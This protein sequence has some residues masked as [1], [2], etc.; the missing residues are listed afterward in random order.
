[1]NKGTPI[2]IEPKGFHNQKLNIGDH[3]VFCARHGMREGYISDISFETHTSQRKSYPIS[4]SDPAFV[5][6]DYCNSPYEEYDYTTPVVRVT[7]LPGPG[8]Y[9]NNK[10][11]CRRIYTWQSA[12]TLNGIPWEEI[13]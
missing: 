6:S 2:V 4:H 12:V 8:R 11:Y 1:M 3:I 9:N 7:I 10:A 5:Y 13:Q